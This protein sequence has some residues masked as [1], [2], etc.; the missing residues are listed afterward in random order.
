MSLPIDL[1]FVRHGESQGNVAMA[2]AKAGD[3]SYFTDEYVTTPGRLWRLTDKG[4]AQAQCTGRAIRSQAA[5]GLFGTVERRYLVSP[6]VRTRMTAGHLGLEAPA[7]EAEVEWRLNRSIRERDWGDIET[8]TRRQFKELFPHSH[9]RMKMDP[10][11]WRMPGGEAIADVVDLR[12]RNLYDTLHRENSTHAVFAVSHGEFMRANHFALI[13]G[14]DELYSEWESTKGM[15]IENCEKFHY[16]RR[17]PEEFAT[18]DQPAGTILP[19]VTFFWRERPVQ[20]ADGAW[21]M[22]LVQPWTRI[23]YKSYSNAELLEL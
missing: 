6:L 9:A 22:E 23:Q 21:E 18:A 8:M 7:G 20:Q 17:V 19:K 14:N 5:A 4:V 15:K 3:E 2:A 16:S 10:L 12:C 13:R 1:I 11:Y